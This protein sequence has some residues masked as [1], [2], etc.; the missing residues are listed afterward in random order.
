M[1]LYSPAL[2]KAVYKWRENNKEHFS[3][4]SCKHSKCYYDLNKEK[5]L[6]AKRQ[7]RLAKKNTELDAKVELDVI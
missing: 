6:A 3:E 4:L 1:R 5:I 2:K 7:K